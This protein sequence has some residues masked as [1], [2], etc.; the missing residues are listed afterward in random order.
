MSLFTLHPQLAADTVPVVDLPLSRV[1]LM[2]DARW[3]WLILVPRRAGVVE[4]ID[5]AAGDAAQL[6]TEARQCGEVLHAQFRP[7]KLNLGALGNVVPQLHVHVIAR[8]RSDPRWPQPVWGAGPAERHRAGVLADRLQQL[9][10]AL[11]GTV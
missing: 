6:W 8:W 7:D 3:P 11:T 1:L 5:L 2:D 9:R 10:S 4:F